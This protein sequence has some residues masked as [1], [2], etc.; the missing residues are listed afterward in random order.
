M[1]GVAVPPLTS[2]F[3]LAVHAAALALSKAGLVTVARVMEVL[4]AL[5]SER[6]LSIWAEIAQHLKGYVRLFAD[7]EWA[8]L[9]NRFVTSVFLML[10]KWAVGLSQEQA[11]SHQPYLLTVKSLSSAR[12][13]IEESGRNWKIWKTEPYPGP[14]SARNWTLKRALRWA[15]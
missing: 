10:R 6:S 2:F 4:S 14:D 1:A 15:L 3:E 5:R 8:P 12:G 11:H 9:L 13:G 7:L